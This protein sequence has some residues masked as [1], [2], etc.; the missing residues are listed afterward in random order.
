MP[1]H[2]TRT[3]AL[4]ALAILTAAPALA[5]SGLSQS[6]SAN[7]SL[8]RQGEIRSL[9]QNQTSSTNQLRMENQQ[10]IQNRPAPVQAPPI[11]VPHR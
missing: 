8:A 7:D 6:N 10:A 11:G 2:H 3:L 1:S 9:Q 5:Q 4:A